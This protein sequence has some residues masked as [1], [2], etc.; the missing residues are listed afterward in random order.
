M[1]RFGMKQQIEDFISY[2]QEVKQA[3]QNTIRAYQNDLKKL[4]PIL[5]SRGF[6]QLQKS[7]RQ[8]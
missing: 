1:R 6:K 7:Q 2:L 4:N 5:V 3:S 8:A